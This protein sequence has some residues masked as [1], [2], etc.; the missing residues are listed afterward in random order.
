M[1]NMFW[2]VG[3]QA[4]LGFVKRYCLDVRARPL[5]PTQ[6]YNQVNQQRMHVRLS[7]LLPIDT[8]LVHESL[9]GLVKW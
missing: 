3:S 1:G 8:I 6:E 9:L 2:L 4:T 5:A 7:F